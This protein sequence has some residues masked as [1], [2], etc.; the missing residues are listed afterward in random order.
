MPKPQVREASIPFESGKRKLNGKGN[1]KPDYAQ[2]FIDFSEAIAYNPS[3]LSIF[4]TEFKPNPL[5]L[6]FKQR[7]LKFFT[8]EDNL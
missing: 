2:A 8:I 4:A 5:F 1:V 6:L 3:K 7:T